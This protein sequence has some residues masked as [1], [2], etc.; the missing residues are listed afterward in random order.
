MSE[1]LRAT[2]E[3]AATVTAAPFLAVEHRG[4]G[5]P[6]LVLPGLFG[7]DL[8]TLSLRRYLTWLNYGVSGWEIGTNVGPTEAVVSGLRA[9]VTQL[10]EGSGRRVSLVGWSLGGLYAHELA[11]RVPG[12]IRQVLTLG[13]PVRLARRHGR[14]TSQ[15]FDRY[16]HL[17][18]A[19]SLVPRPWSEAGQL[20]VPATAVYTRGDGIVAWQS[21]LLAPGKRRENIEV[22]GSHYGLAHN[23]AVLHVLADRLA[24]PEHDWRPFSA[25]PLLRHAYP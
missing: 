18:V 17:N 24:Q 4:D 13:S 6:V 19:P 16:S 1:A 25:G 20:R 15:L 8:S 5:H 11:R 14:A 23:P 2:L 3:L 7:G 21:C 9:R 10:A 12:S 22:Y